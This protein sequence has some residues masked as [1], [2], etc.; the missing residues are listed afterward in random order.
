MSKIVNLSR[1]RKDRTRMKKRQEADENAAKFGRT[2][3]ERVAQAARDE[4]ARRLLDGHQLNP[5]G[6]FEQE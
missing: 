3:A 1:A 4:Q 5:D 2:K 6:E